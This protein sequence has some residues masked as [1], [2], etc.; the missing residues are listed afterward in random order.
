MPSLM[1]SATP[2]SSS[3][4]SSSNPSSARDKQKSMKLQPPPR[5]D[6]TCHVDG[7][8]MA[9]I[10]LSCCA[11][12]FRA[13]PVNDN[14]ENGVR[15]SN[16]WVEKETGKGDYSRQ[17]TAEMQAKQYP[18]LGCGQATRG[19]KKA[20][21]FASTTLLDR[22]DSLVHE[23][24]LLSLIASE[25]GQDCFP[26]DDWRN[27]PQASNVR[28]SRDNDK[29]RPFASTPMFDRNDSLVQTGS[30]LSLIASHDESNNNY[31]NDQ[32]PTTPQMSYARYDSAHFL[33]TSSA[34]MS[35]TSLPMQTPPSPA[36]ELSLAK[37]QASA[38]LMGGGKLNMRRELSRGSLFPKVNSVVSA[39][40]VTRSLKAL[41]LSFPSCEEK[42]D[43]AQE[44]GKKRLSTSISVQDSI[45]VYD[46][47]GKMEAPPIWGDDENI[48]SELKCTYR[49]P[50]LFL[51]DPA[52]VIG[53]SDRMIWW[54]QL[55]KQMDTT[56]RH[57][58]DS[59]WQELERQLTQQQ[60]CCSN[61]NNTSIDAVSNDSS[62]G[63]I[64]VARNPCSPDAIV[65]LL[66]TNNTPP[67]L[68]PIEQQ[69]KNTTPHKGSPLASLSEIS[70][71]NAWSE[72]VASTMKIRGRTYAKDSVKVE[73]ETSL[74]SCL[75]VD[76]FVNGEGVCKDSSNTTHYLERWSKVCAEVGLDRPPFLL[77]I[78]FVVPWGS[79]QLY[80]FRPDADDGPFASRF[81]DRPSEK[82]LRG[83]LEGTTEHRNKCLKLI[84]RICAG[85]WVVKK[86]VGSTP[87][88]I[89]TKLPVSYRGS[90]EENFLEISMDVT[91][92]PAFG[93]TVANTV[94]GKADLVT[95]DLGFVIEGHEEDGTLPE[96]MLSL[97]R[98]HHLE[99]KRAST[100][101][102]WR[103]ELD[104]RQKKKK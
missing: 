15:G 78:N 9:S 41:D 11:P 12:E 35:S 93:N 66:S 88:I 25:G 13:S 47:L 20:R 80:L 92:G 68:P 71:I 82:A 21:P 75:G 31:L 48:H 101:G 30:L 14:G 49:Y 53:N 81:K 43:K 76:S 23:S 95:V 96:Q 46:C 52:S 63:Q 89:G 34:D 24:S 56:L 5:H 44:D 42:S 70:P 7:G 45:S 22:N 61:N 27:T 3:S 84:P 6:P 65:D 67:R 69:Q 39:S 72:P 59:Y 97:V 28:H 51:Q 74:F 86:M 58:F 19:G 55:S 94:V 103:E 79:F 8:G 4:S 40:S 36:I 100:I 16:V 38:Q 37:R 85:P 54:Y 87:A 33:Q 57:A 64:V 91:K 77:V 18:I 102:Q 98:L 1:P 60:D 99:M 2:A 10:M 26:E 62:F 29:P 17:S 83:F 104:K 90:I 32:Y 50:R 73:S